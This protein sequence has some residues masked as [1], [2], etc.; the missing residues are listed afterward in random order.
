M[1]H[2]AGDRAGR[3]DVSSAVRSAAV[4]HVLVVGHGA[5]RRVVALGH[6]CGALLIVLGEALHPASN[7]VGLARGLAGEVHV[8]APQ[9]SAVGPLAPVGEG[10][11]LH[12][13]VLDG[14]HGAELASDAVDAGGVGQRGHRVGE[15]HL[16]LQ[17]FLLHGA[18]RLL[19]ALRLSA[20]E[21]GEGRLSRRMAVGLHGVELRPDGA[22][23]QAEDQRPHGSDSGARLAW[24]ELLATGDLA[25]GVQASGDAWRCLDASEGLGRNF[26]TSRRIGAL[27]PLQDFGVSISLTVPEI[28]RHKGDNVADL[29]ESGGYCQ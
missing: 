28:Q 10:H 14:A 1:H 27:R 7:V 6:G 24:R 20:D 25:L 17:Q 15:F 9:A 11:Q 3:E 12:G 4:L 13:A 21:A 23:Q 16:A 2:A 26:A 5:L 29:G 18:D 22:G 8:K 19:G